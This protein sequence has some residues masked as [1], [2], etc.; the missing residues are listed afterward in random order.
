MFLDMDYISPCHLVFHTMAPGSNLY[1]ARTV[2]PPRHPGAMHAPMP[3][4]FTL[5]D[6]RRIERVPRPL[7]LSP[8]HESIPGITF[9]VNGWAGVRVKD[10]LKDTV[11]VDAA[12]DMVLEHHGWRS[13]VV[14]LEWPGY[15]TRN[16][17][18]PMTSRIDV[19]P[20]GEDI[21]RQNLAREIC[22]LL[23]TFC[24]NISK[25]TISPEC[26]KWALTAGPEGIRVTDIVLLSIHYYRNFWVPEFYVIE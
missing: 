16:V 6:Q 2:N 10:I 3:Q 1:H 25:Y 22:G 14:H 15:D 17:D 9:S 24:K 23:F 4:Y 26:E 19:R 13:I 11:F 21:T 18:D 8:P 7:H 20:G 12:N 5:L